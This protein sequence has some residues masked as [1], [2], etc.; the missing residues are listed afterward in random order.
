MAEDRKP[1]IP[2]VGLSWQPMTSPTL[3]EAHGMGSGDSGILVLNV[4]FGSSAWDRLHPGDVVLAFEGQRIANNGTVQYAGKHRLA[5]SG[6][7]CEHYV[8][9]EVSLE[10]LRGGSKITVA[11]PTE[12]LVVFGGPP[13]V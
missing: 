11:A 5:W 12:T 9:E 1:E 8:G 6:L 7:L 4:G 2:G 10:V 13:A 3:R